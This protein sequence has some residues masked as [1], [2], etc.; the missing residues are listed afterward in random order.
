MVGAP[1]GVPWVTRGEF[2]KPDKMV[3][4]LLPHSEEKRKGDRRGAWKTTRV[5]S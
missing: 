2:G 5:V 3:S 1:G 4:T